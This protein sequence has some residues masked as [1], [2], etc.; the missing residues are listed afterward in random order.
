MEEFWLIVNFE[1]VKINRKSATPKEP[2]EK[3][4][5]DIQTTGPDLNA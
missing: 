1:R 3:V 5:K 4:V 2:A